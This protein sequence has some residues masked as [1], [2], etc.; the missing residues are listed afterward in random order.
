M[1]KIA[2]C[3]ALAVLA[4]CAA[5][6]QGLREVDLRDPKYFR[7]EHIIPLPFPKIQMALFKHQAACGSAPEFFMDPRQTNY[8]TIIQKP[9]GA[10]SFERAVLAD[11]VQLQ[12]TMMAESR[13]RAQVYTYY[14]DAAAEKQINDFLAAIAHPEVCPD[15]K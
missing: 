3:M 11:L 4:G 5:T 9:A 15:A 10:S 8:A 7:A 14:T 13:V 2:M 6:P 1:K 12:G